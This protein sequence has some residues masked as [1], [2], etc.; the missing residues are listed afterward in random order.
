MPA[1]SRSL[2]P[3]KVKKGPEKGALFRRTFFAFSAVS[4]SKSLQLEYPMA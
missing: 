4:F 2:P 3:E 1:K